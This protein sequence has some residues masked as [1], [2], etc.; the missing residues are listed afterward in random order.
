MSQDDLFLF[1]NFDN[2]VKVIIN[3][4]NKSLI[5]ADV[6]PEVYKKRAKLSIWIRKFHQECGTLTPSVEDA[7]E[8]LQE[9]SCLLLM[10]AHQPNLFAYSGVLRKATLNFVLTEKLEKLLKIPIINFFGI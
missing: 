1:D 7:I 2:L 3:Y 4:Y 5:N 6:S 10:T 9:K 8:K